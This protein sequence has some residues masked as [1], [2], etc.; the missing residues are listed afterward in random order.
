MVLCNL[1]LFHDLYY[2]YDFIC[3]IILVPFKG[4]ILGN[5]LN[6]L[7]CQSAIFISF[8]YSQVYHEYVSYVNIDKR[9]IIHTSI[10]TQRI[11]L[12]EISVSRSTKIYYRE[13]QNKERNLLD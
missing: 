1:G 10:Q 2:L 3:L 9:N 12:K 5:F 4:F 13:I 11:K 7:F 6:Y 8:A